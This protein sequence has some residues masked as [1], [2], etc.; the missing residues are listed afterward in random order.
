V[1]KKVIV[2]IIALT[3]VALLVPLFTACPAEPVE[4]DKILIGASRSITGAL[5]FF[6]ENAFGPI[7]KMW[8]EDVNAAGG[9][10]LSDYGK[11]LPVEMDVLDD[12]SDSGMVATNI[13]KLCVQDNVD[14]LFGP[15]GTAPLFAAAPIANKYETIIL[16]AEGGATSLRT[17]MPDLPYVFSVLNFSDHAQ[18]PV[19]AELFEDWGVESVYAIYIADLHG[20][21]YLLI[22][23]AELTKVGIPIVNAVSVPMFGADY[24][25]VIRAAMD[26]GADAFVAWCYPWMIYP[27]FEQSIALGYNPDVWLGGPG[28]NFESFRLAFGDANIE[29]TTGE[30]AWCEHSS[31]AA[32]D[33]TAKF[34]ERWSRAQ[35]DWWGHLPYWG[36]LEF[37]QMA[38]EEAGTVDS[39]T[40]RDVMAT[41]T[42]ETPTLGP[43]YFEMFGDGGGFFGVECYP[44]QIGQWQSGIFEVIDPGVKRT[45]EPQF[46]KPAFPTPAGE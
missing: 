9:I 16:C 20:S 39:K 6:E 21:E 24:A 28:V 34:S 33:F 2:G 23:S 38:L 5:A 43:T 3:I 29:G 45:A 26:S 32:A 35:I 40:V 18:M 36:S 19:M 31:Q 1:K 12:T 42:F 27:A 15:C 41:S 46:P 13:E 4:K 17:M 10:Y 25:S 30:G 37:F 22:G 44:G 14:F 8:A 7:Y 11:S